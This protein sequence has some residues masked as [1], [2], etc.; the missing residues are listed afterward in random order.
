MCKFDTLCGRLFSLS[1]FLLTF[2]PVL[3]GLSAQNC[4]KVC[5][6]Q[7]AQSEHDTR[8]WYHGAGE[9]KPCLQAPPPFPPPQATNLTPF[10][11]FASSPT[12]E[13]E[14]QASN[15]CDRL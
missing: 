2:F 3:L 10:F 4:V 5:N 11:F 6:N 9:S 12:A 7:F 14:S 13:P 1:V 8:I 15:V